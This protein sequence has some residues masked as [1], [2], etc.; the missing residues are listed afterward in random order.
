MGK[1]WKKKEEA[2]EKKEESFTLLHALRMH[3]YFPLPRA[4]S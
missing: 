3:F 4:F 2:K 1:R